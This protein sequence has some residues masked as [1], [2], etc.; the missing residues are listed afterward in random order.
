[1]QSWAIDHHIIEGNPS[2]DDSLWDLVAIHLQRRYR[3]QW[4]GGAMGISS[5]SIDS[6]FATHAVYHFCRT[7]AGQLP[8]RAIKGIPDDKAQIKMP[9]TVQDINWRGQKWVGGIRMW[10]VGTKASEDLLHGQ[11]SLDRPGPGYINYCNPLPQE[12]YAQLTG[13]QRLPVQRGGVLKDLWARTR[14]R[15]EV[16]DCRR[17][18][19]HAALCLGLDSYTA[20]RWTELEHQVQPPHDLFS[21]PPPEPEPEAETSTTPVPPSSPPM[22]P[23]RAQTPAPRPRIPRAFGG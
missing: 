10:G 12:W 16:R 18:A 22:P 13:K 4:H 1:M 11:L 9:A 8:V 6:G 3:Q 15:V 21:S 14:P 20:A 17:Y 5:I 7:H 23:L 2:A 19:H